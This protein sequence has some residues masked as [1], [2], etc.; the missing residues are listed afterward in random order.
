MNGKKI[1]DSYVLGKDTLST[2]EAAEYLGMSWWRLTEGLK[3]N[4]FT[5][6]NAKLGRTGTQYIYTIYGKKLYNYKHG[7]SQSQTDVKELICELKTAV[8]ALATL[9]NQCFELITSETA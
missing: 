9:M 1:D 8:T 3:N 4:E 5:F 7:I 2:H 6:G